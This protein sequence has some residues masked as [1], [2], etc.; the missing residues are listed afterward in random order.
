MTRLPGTRSEL[1]AKLPL[2]GSCTRMVLPI[3]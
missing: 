2:S 3:L 1:A